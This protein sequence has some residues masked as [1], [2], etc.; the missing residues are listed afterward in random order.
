MSGDPAALLKGFGPSALNDSVKQEQSVCQSGRG[1]GRGRRRG[2]H[3][4]LETRTAENGSALCRLEG[5]CSFRAAFRAGR[6]GFRP[7]A[8][9]AR[10]FRLALFTVFGVVLELLIVEEQLL[11]RGEHKFSPAVSTLQNPID[12][13]HGR[14]PQR[15]E[16]VASAII[17]RARRS[18]I[19]VFASP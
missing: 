10:T 3:L 16:K 12:K 4:I 9:T 1:L 5:N 17:M 6:T 7:H 2:F 19:P 18:R 14:L 11:A 15:R 13:F 8:P